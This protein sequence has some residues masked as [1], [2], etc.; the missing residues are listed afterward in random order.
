MCATNDGF[1]IAEKDLELRG[2]GDIEGTRQSGM[3]NF[4]LADL[5]KDKQWLDAAK[6]K[7][8]WLLEVDPELKREENSALKFYL[9]AQ[10]GKLAWSR[11]S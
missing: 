8:G 2:P 10:K 9:Q 7:A 11:I 5:I 6:E 3:L 4:R 1:R